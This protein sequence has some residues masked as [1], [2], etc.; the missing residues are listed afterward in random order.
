M[1]SSNA[2]CSKRC[3]RSLK[4]VLHN[5]NRKRIEWSALANSRIIFKGCLG[6]W[7]CKANDCTQNEGKRTCSHPRWK[8]LARHGQNYNNSSQWNAKSRQGSQPWKIYIL[9]NV[10]ERIL[11]IR[12]NAKQKKNTYRTILAGSGKVWNGYTSII[13]SCWDK[14][15]LSKNSQQTNKR[16]EIS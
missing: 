15:S 9:K 16:L 5:S 7:V 1:G 12:V 4:K 11:W 14:I 10:N 13:K 2:C 3:L 6:S 8:N